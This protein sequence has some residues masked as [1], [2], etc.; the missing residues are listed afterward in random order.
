MAQYDDIPVQRITVVSIAS[1][2]VTII[3]VLAV[4]VIYFGMQSHADAERSAASKYVD[5]DAVLAAQRESLH[6][7][8]VDADNARLVIPI[9]QA[10]SDLIRKTGENHVQQSVGSEET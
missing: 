10:M 2:L 7:S 1:I 5:S 9:E 3:T 6:R 8:G 4:Q